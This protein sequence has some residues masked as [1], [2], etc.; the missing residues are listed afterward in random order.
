MASPTDYKQIA[1]FLNDISARFNFRVAPTM[2]AG[3]PCPLGREYRMQLVVTTNDTSD[4]YKKGIVEALKKSKVVKDI[5]FNELS[6]NSSKYSS[7]TFRFGDVKV[8]AVIS[9]GANK[10][11]NFEKKTVTDLQSAFRS[12]GVSTPYK[13]LIAGM[14][15]SNPAFARNEIKSVKQ[16][17]GSTRKEGVPIEQLGAIIGDIVLTDITGKEWFISLKDS[18][19]DTFSSYSGA[20]TLFDSDGTLQPNLGGATFLKAFGVNLNHVQSGYDQ[21]NGIV[22]KRPNIPLST[23]NIAGISSIFERAWGMNYFYVRKQSGGWKVFW[24]DKKVL[25][26]LSKNI[27]IDNI[28]YPGPDSKQIS[29][30]CSNA[31]ASYLIE[32]RNSKGG[33]YPNDTKFKIKQMR[34]H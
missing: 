26:Q 29:I 1:E 11:E 13:D 25:E 3:K 22:T 27:K 16:R 6:P 2:P 18:N 31:Y 23:P 17:T 5:Q 32:I 21:R 33:E 8:D 9:K 24:L 28:K 15:K 30:L 10:G 4:I 19:G 7:V 34:L 14:I 20:A 12:K